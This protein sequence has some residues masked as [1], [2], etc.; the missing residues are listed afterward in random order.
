M[1]TIKIQYAATCLI[2]Q[3]FELTDAT[4]NKL[5]IA[6]ITNADITNYDDSYCEQFYNDSDIHCEFIRTL[7]DECEGGEFIKLD[8]FEH[9]PEME[10]HNIWNKK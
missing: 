3:E 7:V 5:R 2:T 8:Y 1:K 4:Y 9:I 6:E 10:I